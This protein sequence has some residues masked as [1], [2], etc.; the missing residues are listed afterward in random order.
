MLAEDGVRRHVVVIGASA[1]GVEALR[2]LVAGLPHG[3]DA[4]ILVVLHLPR[5]APSAL[6]AILSR[7][8]DLP[9]RVATAGEPLGTG[10]IYLAP[11]DRHLLLLDQ[12]IRLSS[13]PAEHGHRPAIDP[14]FRSAA[15]TFGPAVIGVLL[16]GAQEDGVAGLG[17][18]VRAGGLAIVQD[19][20][21]ALYPSMP[22]TAIERV[23]VHHVLS[24]T[25]IGELLTALVGWPDLAPGQARAP[26][27]PTE[28]ARAEHAIAMES[29]LWMALRALEEKSALSRR[30][31]ASSR[32]RG[33]FRTAARYQW[34]A[35][36]AE[37]AG[38]LLRE[39]LASMDPD[40][41]PVP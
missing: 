25:K 14:L 23:A 5:D 41:G 22:R 18:I 15:R 7:S 20:Q 28:L 34:L 30:M 1:G 26:V 8:G 10:H 29:A 3:L 32:D 2:A 21:D 31:S 6:P 33:H 39:L 9:A 4:A 35:I 11:A 12:R 16:S 37:R 19:P 27:D 40:T 24:A 38:E 17:A 36:D 13:G